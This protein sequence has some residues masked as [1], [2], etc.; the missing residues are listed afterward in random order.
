MKPIKAYAIRALCP[1]A[2][3]ALIG[4]DE[5]IRWIDMKGD[6]VPSDAAI[7]AKLAELIA[8]YDNKQ[9][10]RDRQDA[11]PTV[12]DQLDNLYRDLLAGKLDSTGDFAKAIKAIK[13]ANPKP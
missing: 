10:Q 1:N 8:A 6:S 13:D 11:Y 2:D 4:T 12:G 5:T 7:D 3:F 9:Y